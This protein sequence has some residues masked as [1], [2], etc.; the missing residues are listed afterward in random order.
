MQRIH[1]RT[2]VC[3]NLLLVAFLVTAQW[4]ALA[5]AF[6]HEA[7]KAQ[8]RVCPTCV[9]ASQLGFACVDSPLTV[10]PLPSYPVLNTDTVEEIKTLHQVTARQ[11]G[12][13]SSL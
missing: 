6:E 13:P 1:A 11:R 3:S 5:H 2:G 12:P 10:D 9:A 4:G 8:D 7:G